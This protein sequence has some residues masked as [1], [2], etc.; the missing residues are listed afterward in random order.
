VDADVCIVGAGIAGLFAAVSLPE[1]TRAVV[2][3]KGTLG[4]GSSPLAQGGMAAAVG[5][6]D[7]PERHL[8]DTVAAGAG[9]VDGRA[10]G[11]LSREAPDRVRELAELGC[12]FDRNPDGSLHLAREGGQS[13]ARS[14]HTADASGGEIVRAIRVAA[15]PRVERVEAYAVDLATRIARTISPPRCSPPPRT[16]RRP[17]ATP[18]PWPPGPGHGWRISSSYS[19]TPPRWRCRNRP[20]RCSPRPSG[21]PAPSSWTGRDTGSWWTGTPTPSSPPGTW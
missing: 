3:D 16:R 7:S 8:A 10:A 1:G 18:W 20:G 17:R 6:S 5:P 14:V 2:L 13:V 9:L 19:S 4:E 11:V 12:R 21:E 15:G